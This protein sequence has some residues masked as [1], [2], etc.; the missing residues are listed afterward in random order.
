MSQPDKENI[1]KAAQTASFLVEDLQALH[2]TDDAILA[3]VAYALLEMAVPL[4]TRLERL[5]VLM[6]ER[7]VK[8]EHS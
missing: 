3:E 2:K 6:T 8:E 5:D 1:E 4:K 7:K